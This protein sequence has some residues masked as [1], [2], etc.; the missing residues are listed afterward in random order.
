MTWREKHAEVAVY[1]CMLKAVAM[2]YSPPGDVEAEVVH[3]GEAALPHEWEKFDLH[4]KIALVKFYHK[5]DEAGWQY[6]EAVWRGAEA[7]V[8][9]DRFPSRRRRMVITYSRDYRFTAGA[10]PPRASG[11][12][13][14]RGRYAP[15][16]S[17]A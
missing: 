13:E 7:V 2:P 11:L 17:C 4:G 12:G 15:P 9:Y 14:L 10:P 5:L 6:L 8:F 1:R 3:V 16:Q